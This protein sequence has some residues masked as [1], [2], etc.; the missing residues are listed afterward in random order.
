MKTLRQAREEHGV[1]Q[2]S[3]ANALRVSRQAYA[4]W[5]DNPRMMPVFQAEAACAFIGCD[6]SEIFFGGKLSKTN[7]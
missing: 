3:V 6:P 2:I 1:T 5:E 7:Q 4:K